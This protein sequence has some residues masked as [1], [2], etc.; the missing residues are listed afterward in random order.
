M[1][2]FLKFN[3]KKKKGKIV[4]SVYKLVDQGNGMEKHLIK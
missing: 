2:K 1:F 4:A 3:E